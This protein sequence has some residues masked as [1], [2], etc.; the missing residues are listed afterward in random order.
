MMKHIAV[1][2]V[3]YEL[4]QVENAV[5]DF[6]HVINGNNYERMHIVYYNRAIAYM[7]DNQHELAIQD[8]TDAIRIKPDFTLALWGR[9]ELY[10]RMGQDQKA[11]EDASKLNK[12]DPD[13]KSYY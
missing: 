7:L 9:F 13:K 1:V 3:H 2:V 11:N 5:A 10:K 6:T 4:F 8:Y 12:L